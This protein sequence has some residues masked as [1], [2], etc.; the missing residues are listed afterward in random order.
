[1]VGQIVVELAAI[2][3]YPELA[4]ARA[5][6]RDYLADA[7][8]LGAGLV[9]HGYLFRQLPGAEVEAVEFAREG[10]H[11]HRR[12]VLARERQ[13]LVVE[14]NGILVRLAAGAHVDEVELVAAQVEQRAAA[15]DEAEGVTPAAAVDARKGLGPSRIGHQSGRAAE[16]DVVPYAVFEGRE[17][18]VLHV[19]VF[20]RVQLLEPALARPAP[21]QPVD[22]PHPVGLAH[23]LED[24]V[25]VAVARV[26]GAAEV[27][28]LELAVVIVVL[29][30]AV[31][32]G[33]PHDGLVARAHEARNG[34]GREARIVGVVVLDGLGAIVV[35]EE[36][37]AVGAEPD[38]VGPRGHGGDAAV[39]H[40]GRADGVGAAVVEADDVADGD[41]DHERVG[42]AVQALDLP[43]ASLGVNQPHGQAV[44]VE[45]GA[46]GLAAVDDVFESART[47]V[48]HLDAA[49]VV[50]IAEE[51][52][53]AAGGEVDA[54]DA[55]AHQVYY[56]V[57]VAIAIDASQRRADFGHYVVFEVEA[58]DHIFGKVDIGQESAG[59]AEPD[60]VV[61]PVLAEAHHAAFRRSE[62][63]ERVADA[64][65]VDAV[66]AG[67]ALLRANPDVAVAVF[68][69]GV[70]A[71]VGQIG[72]E[73]FE[74]GLVR[75]H[76]YLRRGGGGQ[77]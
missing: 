43:E 72:V 47:G 12:V 40:E 19:A 66:E 71:T 35:E 38:A 55:A 27:G 5:P 56:Q 31:A 62:G 6:E 17:E 49:V 33:G 1:M 48:G 54:I 24:H 70:A 52:R 45:R 29:D 42:G 53:G 65:H 21:E 36:A 69:H 46:I 30:Q 13:Q 7:G 25:D 75:Q 39:G 20:R 8:G 10:A 3:R 64:L 68:D 61:A 59:S 63:V 58:P 28:E 41:A 2:G 9:R 14:R 74:V 22:A 67:H 73:D 32:A 76:R 50:D 60:A 23:V 18:I 44:V 77:A 57:A 4:D 15:V 37:V 16:E 51:A 26:G 34:V 11:P